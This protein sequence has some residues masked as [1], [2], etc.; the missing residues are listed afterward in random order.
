MTNPDRSP[1]PGAYRFTVSERSAGLRLDQYL[2]ECSDKFSRSLAKRLIALG[3]VH[4]AGRRMH[5]CSQTVAAG[6]SVEVFIDSQPLEPLKLDKRHILYRDQDLIV[7]DKPAGMATQ[8]APSRYQGTVYAELQNLL[9]D[10]Q[11]KGYRP[12]IG[13]VQRL[14]RDTSG[15]MV[16]SIH[17]RAHK[18]MTEAFQGRDIGKVYWALVAGRPQ[19]E[20]GT[21]RSLLARRRSTNLMVSVARGGK[22]AETHYRLLWTV[23]QVSLVEVQLITGRS[24]QIRAH[25]SEAG[26]PLLGDIAYGGPQMTNHLEIPRQML[27]SRQLSF[28]HPVTG[29]KMLFTAPLPGDFSTVLKHVDVSLNDTDV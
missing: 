12:S 19:E 20:L 14:D 2:A 5:R 6:D 28:R 27:H 24:H 4:L 1:G 29:E 21:F 7:L 23:G 3:G 8:P 22:P 26:L 13:M 18:T 9:T 11:R 17:Q 10:P 15:V 16:F 25:F